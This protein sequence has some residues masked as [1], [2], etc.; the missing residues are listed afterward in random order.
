[1]SDLWQ[2]H[3]RWKGYVSVTLQ[4][5]KCMARKYMTLWEINIFSRYVSWNKCVEKIVCIIIIII[6]RKLPIKKCNYVHK[7]EAFII[8]VISKYMILSRWLLFVFCYVLFLCC[9]FLI[10]NTEITIH[11]PLWANIW[12][13]RALVWYQLAILI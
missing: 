13:E 4:N 12:I 6:L 8:Y 1:M 9:C 5:V 11:C 2:V 10:A 7:L 3:D